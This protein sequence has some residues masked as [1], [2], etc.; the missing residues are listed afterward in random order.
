MIRKILL[1]SVLGIASAA[2]MAA[3]P[4]DINSASAERLAAELVGVGDVRS[5][6]IVDYRE[7]QGDFPSVGALTNVSGIGDA[8]L[9][10]NRDRLTVGAGE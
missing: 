1:G 6:A 10:N 5:Q 8:V 9:A 2:A 3:G 4:I 7:S